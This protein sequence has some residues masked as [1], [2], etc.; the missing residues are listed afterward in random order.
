MTT[1]TRENANRSA[2]QRPTPQQARSAAVLK[3]I[4]ATPG[5]S[6][7]AEFA[8]LGRLSR[9]LPRTG[10]ILQAM[11]EPGTLSLDFRYAADL[12]AKLNGTNVVVG[13]TYSVAWTAWLGPIGSGDWLEPG[14]HDIGDPERRLHVASHGGHE[15][16]LVTVSAAH[17][18]QVD[19]EG[20]FRSAHVMPYGPPQGTE[21]CEQVLGKLTEC[22]GLTE[23]KVREAF[24][25]TVLGT[26]VSA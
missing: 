8:A 24:V 13:S 10:L 25:A 4:V 2:D 5:V 17:L 16:G 1:A 21:V 20:A 14:G 3:R 12:K 19:A 6:D 15:G 23:A 9:P 11:F 22:A 26:V 7:L 18:N